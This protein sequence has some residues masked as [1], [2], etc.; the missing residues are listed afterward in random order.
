MDHE[1]TDDRITVEKE[2]SRLEETF[3]ALSVSLLKYLEEGSVKP[4]ELRRHITV[5]PMSLIRESGSVVDRVADKLESKQTLT[6]LFTF[7]NACMWNFMDYHLLEYVIKR[8]GS[9]NL[10][11]KMECYVQELEVFERHTSVY[12]LIECWPGQDRLPIEN[13]EATLKVE[14]DPKFCTVAE[15]NELRH[16]L[17]VQFWPR[18]SECAKRV[19]RHSTHRG[20]CFVVVWTFPSSLTKELEEAVSKPAT[21][22]LFKENRVLSFSLQNKELYVNHEISTPGRLMRKFCL[23]LQLSTV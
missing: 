18:L 15:L 16:K 14:R 2:F 23:Q 12:D 17:C 7:L 3:H 13:S 21:H 11:R 8:F 1:P 5:L 22:A 10:K 20:G 9:E 19:M 4:N 6:G